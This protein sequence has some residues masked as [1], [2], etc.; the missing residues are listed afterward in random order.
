MSVLVAWQVVK[1]NYSSGQGEEA[2]AGLVQSAQ[3]AMAP[4]SVGSAWETREDDLLALSEGGLLFHG[5]VFFHFHS[6]APGH[7]S[8]PRQ[9][10]T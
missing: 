7:E 3:G 6:R 2:M 4:I 10:G 9:Q 5:S 8:C 1:V